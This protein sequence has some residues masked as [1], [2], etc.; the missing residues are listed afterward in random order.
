MGI[1]TTNFIYNQ[2]YFNF[3]KFLKKNK[4]IDF[5]KYEEISSEE[6]EELLEEYKDLFE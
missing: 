3:L 1:V 6:M 2:A 5:E 4:D